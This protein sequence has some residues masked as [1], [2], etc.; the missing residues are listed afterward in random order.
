M[1]GLSIQKN[2]NKKKSVKEEKDGAFVMKNLKPISK[3]QAIQHALYLEKKTEIRLQCTAQ[4]NLAK[5]TDLCE[6]HRKIAEQYVI[7]QEWE[8][9]AMHLVKTA[10]YYVSLHLDGIAANYFEDAATYFSY[11]RL[12]EEE[13]E[14]LERCALLHIQNGDLRVA[15]RIE[16]KLGDKLKHLHEHEEARDHY[17][18][19]TLF[20]RQDGDPLGSVIP[21]TEMARMSGKLED[22]QRC[23]A[24]MVSIARIYL[25]YNLTLFNSS[26]YF[27]NACLAF[28]LYVEEKESNLENLKSSITEFIQAI[29]DVDTTFA[30]TRECAFFRDIVAAYLKP[31]M[32]D[33]ADQTYM[34]DSVHRF[35]YWQLT[36]L[37]RIH[38]AL[39]FEVDLANKKKSGITDAGEDSYDEYDSYDSYGDSEYGSDNDDDDDD[40]DDDEYL[41]NDDE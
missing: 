10:K 22:Y 8:S 11:A 35:D 19:A 3:K 37:R 23:S 33:F 15:A 5:Y 25:D 30:G 31:S 41:I 18:R 36:M 40:D 4:P 21:A 1:S 14:H 17:E 7:A 29:V 12:Y 32:E 27:L 13:N 39:E 26:I 20:L 6:A 24:E 38:E 9:A 2:N 34:F 28:F 16:M